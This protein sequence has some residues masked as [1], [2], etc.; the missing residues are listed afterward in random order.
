MRA[1]HVLLCIFH[2][3]RESGIFSTLL[4]Y[5]IDAPLPTACSATASSGCDN[6]TQST[7]TSTL[8]CSTSLHQHTKAV[9]S[10]ENDDLQTPSFSS[11]SPASKDRVSPI[12]C[13]K[14]NTHPDTL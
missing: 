1:I 4:D 10:S 11:S 12:S 2:S 14:L 5:S 3:E 9:T 8:A 7:C 13:H 6:H